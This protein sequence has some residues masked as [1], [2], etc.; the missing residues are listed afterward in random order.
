M[1]KPFAVLFCVAPLLVAGPAF[2]FI[3]EKAPFP[4][5][6]AA[7][8]VE[9]RPGQF[10]AA[11]FGG[12]D[13]GNKDV[14]IWGSHRVNGQ[15]SPPEELAREPGTPTWNP[16]LF[17]SADHT[18]WL[19]YKFGTSPSSWTAGRRASRDHGKTWGAMEHLPAGLIGPVKDKPLV[20]PGG[21]IVSGSSVESYHSWAAWIERSTDNGATWTKHGPITVR[22]SVA[23]GVESVPLAAVPG[24]STWNQTFG[25]IQPAV[26]PLDRTGRR[27]RLFARATSNIGWI[28][29]ADSNDAGITWTDARPTTLPNPNSGIDAVGLKDGRI[30]MIYNHTKRGRTPLNLAVSKDGGETWNNF[31]ALETEPGEYSY[32]AIIQAKDGSIHAVYTWKRQRIRYITLKLSQIP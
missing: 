13:E 19:Y 22:Q 23:G 25:L 11:W 17:Y 24:S 4:S 15:W 3:F 1:M 28:C 12:T 7:T 18:L 30:V 26:V 8:I 6:H 32:P 9:T 14:A 21:A 2:E 16:V 27:L 10:L 5:C 20:L 29:S 31:V